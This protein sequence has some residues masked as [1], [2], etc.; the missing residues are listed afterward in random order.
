MIIDEDGVFVLRLPIRPFG[1]PKGYLVIMGMVNG[2]ELV[3]DAALL[4]EGGEP[5][6]LPVG[7]ITHAVLG[8]EAVI[9]HVAADKQ[10]LVHQRSGDGQRK[11]YPHIIRLGVGVFGALG[12]HEPLAVGIIGVGIDTL[13]AR[14]VEVQ[15][16]VVLALSETDT[17]HAVTG[18]V[19]GVGIEMAILVT[20]FEDEGGLV[21]PAQPIRFPIGRCG[22]KDEVIVTVV[23]L[24]GNEILL[25]ARS[26]RESDGEVELLVMAGNLF[27][28]VGGHLPRDGDGFLHYREHRYRYHVLFIAILIDGERIMARAGE[29]HLLIREGEGV[30]GIELPG[31]ERMVVGIDIHRGEAREV[32]AAHQVRGGE[33]R[34]EVGDGIGILLRIV[35]EFVK[36]DLEGI[37]RVGTVDTVTVKDE[38]GTGRGMRLLLSLLH[39][40]DTQ[41]GNIRLHDTGDLLR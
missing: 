29:L 40:A 10:R 30:M 14:A 34:I 4:D 16:R 2:P 11:V 5:I 21:D 15:E 37:G 26:G 24:N 39:G 23:L 38:V 12:I 7:V 19:D 3:I 6:L 27:N 17:V 8:R 31:I 20:A 36:T 1:L 18:I 32:L 13:L 28:G 35:T 33:V 9:E 22:G 41:G 25:V